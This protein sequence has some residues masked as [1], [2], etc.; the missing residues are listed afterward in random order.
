MKNLKDMQH[1][2]PANK[3]QCGFTLVEMAIALLIFNLVLGAALVTYTRY[4][5][6]GKEERTF[7]QIE[8]VA[9]AISLFAQQNMRIPCPANPA[10]A[11]AATG[12]ED[13]SAA[14]PG[15]PV[16]C[17]R[18]EGI[19]PYATL[20]LPEDLAR[21]GFNNYYTYRVS[22]APSVDFRGVDLRAA[23]IAIGNWCMTKPLWDVD[24]PGTADHVN[25][26]KAAFCCGSFIDIAGGLNTSPDTDILIY[27]PS[28]DPL[29]AEDALFPSRQAARTGSDGVAEY[30]GVG[31]EVNPA[32]LT[33]TFQST[34]VAYVLVSHG[35][36]E[37]GAFGN[38]GVRSATSSAPETENSDGDRVFF[39]SDRISSDTAGLTTSLFRPD[40]DDIVFWQS[41]SQILTRLGEESC[42]R[43]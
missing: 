40:I 27:G 11:A 14:V 26:V 10:A 38:S 15:T 32:S 6:A 8:F 3:S 16:E 30:T 29:D 23:P 24:P 39:V 19:L 31:T 36:N 22:P 35:Q 20:G 13:Q 25:P 5:A 42:T 28:G 17:N 7:A 4:L 21:D 43:P 34:F 41:P 9:D 33:G 37:D 18:L 2:K 12:Y 1:T